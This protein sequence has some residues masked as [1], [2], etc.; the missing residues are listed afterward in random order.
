MYQFIYVCKEKISTYTICIAVAIL[1][2]MILL[3]RI[4]KKRMSLHEID[5]I[6]MNL[7]FTIPFVFAGAVIFDK[8]AHSND[9]NTYGMSAIGG[10]ILGIVCFV[11]AHYFIFDSLKGIRKHMCIAAPYVALGHCIGRIGCFLG[12]CC[13]GRPSDSIIAVRFPKDSLAFLKY[14]D[15]KVLPTQLF[16]A[17]LLLLIFFI[18]ITRKD[19]EKNVIIYGLS[20]SIGRFIIEFFRGDNRGNIVSSFFSPTQWIC[21]C[22]VALII[23]GMGIRCAIKKL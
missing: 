1:V 22:F 16:E 17:F 23:I 10:I 5:Q 9:T 7:A 13:F 15:V 8:I 21:L 20:Y 11:I 14:G 4:E 2:V 19:R 18:T 3:E 12:G 6:V